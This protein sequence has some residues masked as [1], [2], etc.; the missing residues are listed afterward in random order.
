MCIHT[1]GK[2]GKGLTPQK[3]D[4]KVSGQATFVIDFQS[5]LK[6]KMDSLHESTRPKI[7][8]FVTKPPVLIDTM[9][10]WIVY[11][12]SHFV[13]LNRQQAFYRQN[14]QCLKR[15]NLNN[16][17]VLSSRI[18][19][20]EESSVQKYHRFS[21]L[22]RNSGGTKMVNKQHKLSSTKFSNSEIENGCYK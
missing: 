22:K 18:S 14:K 9:T 16:L 13:R 15:F 7:E 3:Q 8:R 6:D 1:P 19:T 2:L 11:S 20:E 4:E 10:S 17:L 21:S 12:A 5:S